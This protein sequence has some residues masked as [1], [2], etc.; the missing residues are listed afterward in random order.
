ME[1]VQRASSKWYNFILA[2]CGF[3]GLNPVLNSVKP[4]LSD[5]DGTRVNEYRNYNDKQ[6]I[7]DLYAEYGQDIKKKL[8]KDFYE[9]GD[10]DPERTYSG[11]E[12][13]HVAGVWTKPVKIKPVSPD[14]LPSTGAKS[15]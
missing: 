14:L 10:A 15:P 2:F 4:K 6:G 1:E 9:L 12:V 8:R 13:I 5:P 3:E 11:E 7:T